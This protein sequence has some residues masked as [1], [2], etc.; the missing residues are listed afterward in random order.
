MYRYD[1][2]LPNP[3]ETVSDPLIFVCTTKKLYY[4]DWRENPF[5]FRRKL[6]LFPYPESL[7]SNYEFS[8]EIHCNQSC[9]EMQRQNEEFALQKN[10]DFRVGIAGDSTNSSPTTR[11]WIQSEHRIT[12]FESD[13]IR[14]SYHLVKHTYSWPSLCPFREKISCTS[15][16][17]DDHLS[18]HVDI[19]NF[20][21]FSYETSLERIGII[22]MESLTS[23]GPIMSGDWTSIEK[24]S[25]PNDFRLM[26]F[27]IWNLNPPWH[28]RLDLII[29]TIEKVQPHIIALQEVRF[30]QQKTSQFYNQDLKSSSSR[31]RSRNLR[32]LKQQQKE[33]FH[34]MSDIVRAL[35][36]GYQYVYQPAMTY[37]ERLPNGGFSRIDEGLAIL[38][39]FPIVE[40]SF[41]RLTRNFSDP[42]DTHQRLC[43]RAM[44]RINDFGKPLN[45]FVS[46]W[47][48]SLSARKRNALEIWN[49]VNHFSQP[50]ILCGD[51]NDT[52]D[53]EAV[54]FLLGEEQPFSNGL[55]GDFKDAWQQHWKTRYSPTM[56]REEE[57]SIGWTFTAL[58]SAPKKRIDFILYRSL[59]EDMQ[60]RD[61]QVVDSDSDS[62]LK[63]SDHRAI[64]ASFALK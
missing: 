18:K 17:R 13:D 28:D 32:K 61:F 11:L 14:D 63:A 20:P 35:P 34:Q 51:F 46:H 39:R 23:L 54:R 15:N 45:V 59:L 43:L 38:S 55:K 52:P 57:E 50:Q 31:K 33:E 12:L 64:Y 29:K 58:E 56:D 3:F 42:Q 7:G 37:L 2:F 6:S 10:K 27:N 47:S 41:L 24:T 4:R 49:F 53:S 22:P 62:S 48:L 25:F 5:S 26:S 30:S 1:L 16:D 40:T 44:I 36:S 60:F 19:E 9:H 21:S 8:L